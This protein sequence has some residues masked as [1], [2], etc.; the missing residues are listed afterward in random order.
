[1]FWDICTICTSTAQLT[2]QPK[3]VPD[4]SSKSVNLLDPKH[5]LK[6]TIELTDS[7]ECVVRE[8]FS[9]VNSLL[10]VLCKMI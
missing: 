1:M 10:N 7:S 4:I 3:L 2:M 8:N 9:E 5:V 6:G